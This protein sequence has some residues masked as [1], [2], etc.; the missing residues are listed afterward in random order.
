MPDGDPR[1]QG[2]ADREGGPVQH[3]RPARARRVHQQARQRGPTEAGGAGDGRQQ[4]VGLHPQWSLDGG[5]DQRG[6]GGH[7]ERGGRAADRLGHGDV[8]QPR[9]GA[10]QLD[11]DGQ[12]CGGP[13]E[14]GHQR[15][16]PGVEPVADHPAQWEQEEPGHHRTAEYERQRAGGAGGPGDGDGQCGGDDGVA[17]GGDGPAGEE[18]A[19]VEEPEWVSHDG[20]IFRCRNFGNEISAVAG[21]A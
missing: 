15:H 18:Q 5:R 14:V 10:D 7:G 20:T 4:G 13:N 2:G 8:E 3:E 19:E 9:F 17:E 21:D 11:T 1:Q 16:H 12:L 6:G